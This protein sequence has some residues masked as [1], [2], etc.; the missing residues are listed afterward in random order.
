MPKECKVGD[1]NL[2]EYHHGCSVNNWRRVVL[3]NG[4]DLSINGYIV[5][6]AILISYLWNLCCTFI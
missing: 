6:I 5:V 2:N 3:I 1:N 4:V